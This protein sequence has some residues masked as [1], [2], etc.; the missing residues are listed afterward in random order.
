MMFNHVM[1]L[2]GGTGLDRY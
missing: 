1:E 2:Y